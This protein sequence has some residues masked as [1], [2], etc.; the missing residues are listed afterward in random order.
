MCRTKGFTP[1]FLALKFSL[2]GLRAALTLQ[3]GGEVLP[4]ASAMTYSLSVNPDAMRARLHGAGHVKRW[5]A[6]RRVL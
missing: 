3:C 2:S 5:A 6:R 1:Q 4:Q